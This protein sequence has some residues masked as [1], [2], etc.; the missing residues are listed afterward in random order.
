MT[1]APDRNHAPIAGGTFFE[2][3]LGAEAN[4]RRRHSILTS[5]R[6]RARRQLLREFLSLRRQAR[7]CDFQ[8]QDP[9]PRLET[10]GGSPKPPPVL[11]NAA[12]S[13]RST[14]NTAGY[15]AVKRELSFQVF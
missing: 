12:P 10:G 6:R 8:R 13:G 3:S 14:G 1:S 15:I 4:R 5:M 2:V 9:F 11:S 7:I